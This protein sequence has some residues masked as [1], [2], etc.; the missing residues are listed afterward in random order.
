MD[1]KRCLEDGEADEIVKRG[2]QK[3]IAE[4]IADGLTEIKRITKTIPMTE[5]L[6]WEICS[7]GASLAILLHAA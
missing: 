6:A 1:N 2:D 4:L 7:R 3:E 5:D